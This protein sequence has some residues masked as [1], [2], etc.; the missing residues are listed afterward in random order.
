M[1][2]H[3]YVSTRDAFSLRNAIAPVES[4]FFAVKIGVHTH[5]YVR[6][7]EDL[8][9]AIDPTSDI[10]GVPTLTSDEDMYTLTDAGDIRPSAKAMRLSTTP[11]D[12]VC[13]VTS[14]VFDRL[15]SAW[16]RSQDIEANIMEYS[17]KE[18][19]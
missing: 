7:G 10:T 13:E 18:Q 3:T 6:T 12:V 8:D 4:A 11:H 19:T 1:K 14:E 5:T 17:V 15:L 16:R 9:R 2:L